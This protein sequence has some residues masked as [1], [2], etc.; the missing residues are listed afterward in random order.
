MIGAGVHACVNLPV[1]LDSQSIVYFFIVLLS[2]QFFQGV[3]VMKR[4]RSGFTLIELLVVIAIIAVLVALLLP[5]V[6]QAREAARRSQCKNN[7]KQIGLAIANYESSFTVYP[8][9]KG[10]SYAV[11]GPTFNYA[12][13]SVHSM[14]LPYLEQQNLANTIDFN[15]P[16][17]TPGMA[18]GAGTFMPAYQSPGGINTIPSQTRVPAFL[19]PSD[20]EPSSG[21][22]GEN[23]YC[24]NQGSWLCD[25]GSAPATGA[26]DIATSEV[27]HG[28][29]YYLSKVR[30]RDVSDGLSNTVFFSEKIRG[31]GNADPKADLFVILNQP[32]LDATYQACMAINTATTLALTSKWGASW[33]MG[34]NCCTLYNHV[35]TPNTPSCAGKPFPGTMTNM[36]MQVSAS[37]RHVGAVSVM[38]GDGGVHMVT[39]SI[40]LGVWRSLGTRDGGETFTSPF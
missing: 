14:L 10:A 36:A 9:G 2:F 15:N 39:S 40:D 5:A 19:C 38:M 13:W 23:N 3:P 18:V 25:R 34:E 11:A 22:A 27:N 20:L 1:P 32:S 30:A 29:F 35:A 37:S 16:P 7:L 24:G 26:L 6:Q 33:V 31:N 28:V 4:L 21:W 8:F 17:D 12:R